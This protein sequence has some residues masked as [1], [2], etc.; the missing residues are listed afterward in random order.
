MVCCE[1]QEQKIA[2]LPNGRLPNCYDGQERGLK[3]M[4]HRMHLY[5]ID[6]Y[7][8][9]VNWPFTVCSHALDAFCARNR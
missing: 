4:G 3:F 8:F 2:T 6:R 5:L 1:K 9:E 7:K